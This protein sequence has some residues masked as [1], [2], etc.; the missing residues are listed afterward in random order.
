[1]QV[2]HFDEVEM[3]TAEA[4]SDVVAGAGFEPATFGL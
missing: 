3:L 1:M 2:E 4:C